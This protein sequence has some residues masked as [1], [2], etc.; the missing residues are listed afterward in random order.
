MDYIN[1]GSPEKQNIYVCIYIYIHIPKCKMQI[2]KLLEDN[3][4]EN[5]DDL[6][7]GGDFLD[8]TQKA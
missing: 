8:T 3:I 7:Y 6:V 2:M 4:G 1:S 5:L